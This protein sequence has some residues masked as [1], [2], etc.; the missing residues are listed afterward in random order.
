MARTA[1]VEIWAQTDRSGPSSDVL[2][3]WLPVDQ[4]VEVPDRMN[5]HVALAFWLCDHDDAVHGT[6]RM[7]VP[8]EDREGRA[9]HHPTDLRSAA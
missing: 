2:M 6:Y 5:L 9:E 1:T 8:G 7:R 3:D 4:D